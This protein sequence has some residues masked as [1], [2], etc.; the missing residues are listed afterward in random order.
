MVRVSCNH[1]LSWKGCC[2]STVYLLWSVLD[3]FTSSEIWDISS[4]LDKVRWVTDQFDDTDGWLISCQYWLQNSLNVYKSSVTECDN[5]YFYIGPCYCN[6]G[7][8]IP[9]NTALCANFN[10]HAYSRF[11]IIMH[12]EITYLII[13]RAF[14]WPFCSWACRWVML[15]CDKFLP[16]WE[17]GTA[18]MHSVSQ[19][20]PHAG[21]Q[22]ILSELL[23]FRQ[24]KHPSS[25]LNMYLIGNLVV[26]FNEVNLLSHTPGPVFYLHSSLLKLSKLWDPNFSF[27]YLKQIHFLSQSFENL[28][29]QGT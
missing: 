24:W 14:I 11:G 3:V 16:Y 22:Y 23:R 26:N 13:F 8:T 20:Q 6:C 7:S 21:L 9:L 4:L 5:I 29:K 17:I 25:S 19:N 28:L 1:A 18:C 12:Y 10:E 27:N 2:Q 15:I